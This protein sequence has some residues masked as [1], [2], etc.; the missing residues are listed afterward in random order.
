MVYSPLMSAEAPRP[1][2]QPVAGE[3]AFDAADA[4]RPV[5]T[6]RGDRFAAIGEVALCSGF[7]TQ[8]A[9]ILVLNLIGTAPVDAAGRLSLRYIVYLSLADAT[10]VLLLVWLLLRAHGERP[11]AT[12]V[13]TRPPGREVLLGM[14]LTPAAL[15]IAAVAF[16]VMLRIAPWLH[17]VSENPLEALIRSPAAAVWFSVLSVMAG[18]LREEVQRAFILRRFEQHLGGGMVGLVIFS[19][20]FGLGHLVQGR[21]AAVVTALLGA[22]WGFL[23]LKRRSVVAPMVCHAIFNLTQV[24]VAYHGTGG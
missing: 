15:L 21:D 11:V 13:G 16:G 20:A 5:P 6:A 23:Y 1:E 10:L 19:A 14:A 2:R 18:G 8:L 12:F 22:F 3:A 17:N 4:P 7:P 9:V 24:L